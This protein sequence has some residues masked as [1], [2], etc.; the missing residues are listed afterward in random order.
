MLELRLV[1]VKIRPSA[2]MTS[3]QDI[4]ARM[5]SDPSFDELTGATTL[6]FKCHTVY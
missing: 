3:V 2:V 1:M 4:T 6:H 5:K